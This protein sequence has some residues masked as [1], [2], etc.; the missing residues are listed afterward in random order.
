MYDAVW[1]FTET[2]AGLLLPS[3][4][5]TLANAII[6]KVFIKLIQLFIRTFRFRRE[7]R[8]LGGRCVQCER[9]R[10]AQITKEGE[11][12]VKENIRSKKK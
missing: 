10:R 12:C 2:F 4:W 11:Y 9:I 3:S 7:G 1:V 5:E 8:L 6:D